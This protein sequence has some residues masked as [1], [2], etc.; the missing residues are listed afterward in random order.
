MQRG[1]D[2]SEKV[3][4]G[5]AHGALMHCLDFVGDGLDDASLDLARAARERHLKTHVAERVIVH[6]WN[7]AVRRRHEHVHRGR[8]D[9]VGVARVFVAINEVVG[10]AVGGAGSGQERRLPRG[11]LRELL[12]ARAAE[13]RGAIVRRPAWCIWNPTSFNTM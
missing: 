6:V 10:S 4:A 13:R 2:G 3:L 12:Q 7:R 1:R 8:A 5:V 11:K 9:G